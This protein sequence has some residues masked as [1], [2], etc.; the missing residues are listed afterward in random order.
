MTCRSKECNCDK[1]QQDIQEVRTGSTKG[2]NQDKAIQE[3]NKAYD[4]FNRNIKIINN[5]LIISV[6][7][8]VLSIGALIYYN[9]QLKKESKALAQEN[10]L[11]EM[12]I[13]SNDI[14]L[15]EET[16]E[17]SDYAYSIMVAGLYNTV[18]I[19]IGYIYE[20]GDGKITNSQYK[21][22]LDL[23]EETFFIKAE[24]QKIY[25]VKELNEMIKDIYGDISF[26]N[27]IDE[28]KIDIEGIIDGSL[29]WEGDYLVYQMYILDLIST[30]EYQ[31][32]SKQKEMVLNELT[33]E[34]VR[35][36]LK[37]MLEIVE[38]KSRIPLEKALKVEDNADV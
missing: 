34:K 23:Y 36:M 24:I 20:D 16:K 32:Y 13:E 30:E 28:E 7:I 26:L 31:K 5:F 10:R 38:K 22:F 25:D 3:V 21:E 1:N 18:K 9:Y 2:E 4:K 15:S 12:Q 11:L 37:Y 29:F 14:I 35:Y 17:L 27:R 19:G 8:S 33:P 6:V